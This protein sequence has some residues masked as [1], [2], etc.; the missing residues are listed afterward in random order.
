MQPSSRK[1]GD[2]RCDL[3]KTAVDAED[4][5]ELRK[6]SVNGFFGVVLALSWWVNAA[7]TDVQREVVGKAVDDVLWVLDEMIKSPVVQRKRVA[8]P[9]EAS[10][11]KRTRS[12]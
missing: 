1:S 5:A 3:K 4:W 6:G 9:N 2:G 10:A 12:S 8:E 7:N 11:H